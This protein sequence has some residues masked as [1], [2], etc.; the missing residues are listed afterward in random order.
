M[1]SGGFRVVKVGDDGR[2]NQFETLCDNGNRVKSNLPC[3]IDRR[4]G[5]KRISMAIMTDAG[6]SEKDEICGGLL[7]L[8]GRWV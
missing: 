2:S 1:D 3:H 7:T 4:T 6:C 5:S 8:H